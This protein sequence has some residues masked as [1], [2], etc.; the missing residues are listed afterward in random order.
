VRRGARGP[1]DRAP[2]ASG[3]SDS[4]LTALTYQSL[5]R[6]APGSIALA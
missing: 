1:P 3:V 5:C 6:P 2:P 4:E